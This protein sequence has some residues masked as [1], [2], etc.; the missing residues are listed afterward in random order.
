M[1]MKLDTSMRISICLLGLFLTACDSPKEEPKLHVPLPKNEVIL[2]ADSPK[3]AYIKEAPVELVQRPLMD[4]ITG[5]ITYNEIYTA[6]VTSP[7]SGRVIGSFAALGAHINK[8]DRLAQLDSPDLGQAQSDYADALADQHLVERSF[9]RTRELFTNGIVPRKEQDQAQDNL[10]RARNETERARLKLANLGVRSGRT[11]NR[12]ALLA[13][14]SGQITERNI[15]PGMEVRPDQDSP[16]FVISDLSN[17]WLQMDVFEKDIGLIH[18][19][20]KVLVEVP[21][22]PGETFTATVTFISQV[23]DETTRTV[24][25]RCSL[26]NPRTRLLPAMYAAID[27]QSA[28]D[29]KAMVVPLGA[30]FTENESDWM[31]IDKGNGHYLMRPVKVGLRLKDRAVILDGIS[32]GENMVVDGALLLRA[33][34]NIKS[35]EPGDTQQ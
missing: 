6:R 20:A 11:D 24:K 15:N 25:V 13:P 33:E 14:V 27:V 2:K 18:V 26:P 16:L 28:P 23:V 9:Q 32:P 17:L 34:E 4:P 21:A 7:I 35:E 3:R 10:T 1:I 29:D 5:K 8:G 30:L 12:F 31:F 22:Y 19:G